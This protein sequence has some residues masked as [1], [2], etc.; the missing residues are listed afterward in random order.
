[1]P[2]LI[3]SPMRSP[4]PRKPSA[5]ADSTPFSFAGS[6]AW[7]IDCRFSKTV[8]TSTVTLRLCSTAPLASSRWLA[9]DAGT[10]R[11]T[12]LAPNAVLDLISASMLLGR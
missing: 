5:N 1:M 3:A 2:P 12:Y 9:P 8:L 10:M 4:L 6:I 11:S 7:T